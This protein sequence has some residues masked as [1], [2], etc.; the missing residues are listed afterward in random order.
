[1]AIEPKSKSYYRFST[2]I[3]E[4]VRFAVADQR[5]DETVYEDLVK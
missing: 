1:V 5:K 2:E 4:K 3:Q